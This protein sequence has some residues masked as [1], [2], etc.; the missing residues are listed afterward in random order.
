MA[1]KPLQGAVKLS[2]LPPRGKAIERRKRRNYVRG[3]E[4]GTILFILWS[5]HEPG[6]MKEVKLWRLIEKLDKQRL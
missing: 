2:I 6:L 3:R 1:A 4:R 5:K